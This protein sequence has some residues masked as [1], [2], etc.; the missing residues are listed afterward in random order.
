LTAHF[1]EVERPFR[2]SISPETHI[3]TKKK[4]LIGDFKQAGRSWSRASFPINIHDFFQDSQGRAVGYGI[5]DVLNNRGTVYVG[6]S[7]HARL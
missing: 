3:D 7:A 5:Y 1:G 2:C 4:E 6:T